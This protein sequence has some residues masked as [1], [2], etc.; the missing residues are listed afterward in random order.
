M[1]DPSSL[2]VLGLAASSAQ[3]GP[4]APQTT[5]TAA[6]ERDRFV[7]GAEW[8]TGTATVSM[9]FGPDGARTFGGA[10]V[11]FEPGARTAWHSHPAGQTLVVTEGQG[12]V[13]AEGEPR[14]DLKPGDVV[15]TPPG[16]R[17]WHGATATHAMTHLALQ[18]EVEGAV[19]AWEEHVDDAH[20]LG[21]GSR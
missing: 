2:L 5:V 9:L 6:T 3:A 7:G 17:H 10:S 14:R 20:Y 8:F 16:V 19:V 11:A 12:W 4:P 13:Q 15:W 18:G 21:D 1:S